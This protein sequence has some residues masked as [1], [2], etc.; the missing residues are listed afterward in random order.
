M[1]TAT[2]LRQLFVLQVL[3]WSRAVLCDDV[4][5]SHPPEALPL[6]KWMRT[7]RSQ[8][9]PAQP[10]PPRTQ[11]T[12]S[13]P[14][15]RP[16]HEPVHWTSPPDHVTTTTAD[17]QITSSSPPERIYSCRPCAA[18]IGLGNTATMVM[19]TQLRHLFV[20]QI[21]ALS[22]DIELNPGPNTSSGETQ[23]SS[24]LLLVPKELQ[25]GQAS[26]RQELKSIQQKLS[27][28]DSAIREVNKRLTEIESDCESIMAT[29]EQIE[30]IL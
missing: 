8:T 3:L 6:P 27:Q 26:M 10:N 20:M 13:M 9:S 21:L 11:H 7:A 23:A 19:A 29:K 30:D 5:P 24:D 16:L 28:S 1:V 4:R 25:S 18:P 12:S 17:L 14:H 22:G 2:H 15:Q